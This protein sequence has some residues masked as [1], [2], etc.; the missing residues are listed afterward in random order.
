MIDKIRMNTIITIPPD[1]LQNGLWTRRSFIRQDRLVIFYV[2]IYRNVHIIY[3]PSTRR[4]TVIGRL[5]MASTIP[6]LVSNLDRLRAGVAELKT[7]QHHQ[8]TDTGIEV[9]YTYEAISQNLDEFVFE[10]NQYLSD[11]LCTAIN[12]IHF[13]V[14]Y[15]EICFNVYAKYVE[16]YMVR[17]S[18]VTRREAAQA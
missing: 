1:R 18:K 3:N 5:V 13:Q 8:K 10:F 16:Q 12:I 11:L 9:T 7:V 14:T 17:V 15:I 2:H 4:L 6:D